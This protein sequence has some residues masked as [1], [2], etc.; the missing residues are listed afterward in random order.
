MAEPLTID[1][2]IAALERAKLESPDGGATAVRMPDDEPVLYARLS[3]R[4][5]GED[6]GPELRCC[7]Y[8]GDQPDDDD[9]GW[10]P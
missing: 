3:L 4:E 6:L 7:V 1:G 9:E 5:G 8:I 10:P 2:L